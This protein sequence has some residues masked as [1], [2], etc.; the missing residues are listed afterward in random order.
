MKIQ[1]VLLLILVSGLLASCNLESKPAEEN[2]SGIEI[3]SSLAEEYVRLGLEIGQYDQ[4]FVD[5]Y[6]GPDSLK[7]A[8]TLD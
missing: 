2:K 8:A 1:I 7:P 6:Y 5:A 3:I 4:S